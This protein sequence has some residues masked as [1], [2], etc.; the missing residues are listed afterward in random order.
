MRA[1]LVADDGQCMFEG[2]D[3]LA[4][5]DPA[6]AGPAAVVGEGGAHECIVVAESFGQCGGVEQ[7]LSERPRAG[8]ALRVAEP[9][10]QLETRPFVFAGGVDRPPVPVLGLLGRESG[11]RRS[12]GAGRP[13]GN[14][15][16][17]VTSGRRPVIGQ[18]AGRAGFS[19]CRLDRLGQLPVIQAA[20]GGADAFVDRRL[21][22]RVG[23]LEPSDADLSHQGGL[24]GGLHRVE[25]AQLRLRQHRREQLRVEFPPGHC[26]EAEHLFTCRPETRHASAQHGADGA[27]DRDSRRVDVDP[28]GP[29]FV[30]ADHPCLG[31]VPQQ[32]GGEVRVPSGLVE[33]V[34]GHRRSG[35]TERVAGGPLEQRDE[36]GE[37]EPTDHDSGVVRKRREI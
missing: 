34:R 17:V 19:E 3:P 16:T 15:G 11:H 31:E 20:A 28:P 25:H 2:G 8:P 33:Q 26:G 36:I 12:T 9:D 30:R 5:N 22:E 37:V 4:V 18:H 23:E 29:P 6:R 14:P 32:L 24:N 21:H 35:V 13:V 27:R 1:V 7:R 10:Q